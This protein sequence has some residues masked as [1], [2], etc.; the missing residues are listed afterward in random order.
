M[1][2]HRHARAADLALERVV[3]QQPARDRER[4]GGP[5]RGPRRHRRRAAVFRDHDVDDVLLRGGDR[6]V[7]ALQ[8]VHAFFTRAPRHGRKRRFRRGDRA[9]RIDV[10]GQDHG[11]RCALRGRVEQDERLAPVRGD[12]RAVNINGI[13]GLHGRTPCER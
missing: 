2:H 1:R 12:E 9:L 10:V 5:A 4:G 11:G 3:G 8:P 7:Q 6:L 13:D